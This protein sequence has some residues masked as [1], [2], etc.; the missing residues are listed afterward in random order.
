MRRAVA[1]KED[2]MVMAKSLTTDVRQAA[3]WSI[4]LSLL[5]I[6][7]GVLAICVPVI[8][9]VAITALVGWVL[10]FSGLLHLG[11]AWRAGRAA[12]VVWEIL[13]GIVYG[14][15]GL[16][17]LANPAAGL[18]S[19]TLAIAFYLLI[20]GVLEFVLSFQLRPAP[21][22]GWLLVDGVITLLLAVMIWS[23]WPSSA[24]W[25]VGTLIGISMLFSGIT[26]LM[27]SLAVRRVVS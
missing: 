6:V 22:S 16:Y 12:G 24:A 20:E 19:L 14:A 26:R 4:V 15:I 17:V 9:G 11:F 5:M 2:P 25:V 8:A 27:L 18:A 10:I 3:G 21:G 1:R 23:T 7:A 13:L